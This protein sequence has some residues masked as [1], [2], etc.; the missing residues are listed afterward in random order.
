MSSEGFLCIILYVYYPTI[1]S[2]IIYYCKLMF[3]QVEPRRVLKIGPF[4]IWH[5]SRVLL[6]LSLLI[7]SIFNLILL[8]LF[9][10]FARYTLF[11]SGKC[12]FSCLFVCLSACV[13][14][15]CYTHENSSL[16]AKLDASVSTPQAVQLERVRL[17]KIINTL[18][19]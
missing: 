16:F 1:Y 18:H 7:G 10:N 5:F 3:E 19:W 8:I 14:A 2:C 13:C 15:L 17:Q 6:P 12:I 9:F 4:H 11:D